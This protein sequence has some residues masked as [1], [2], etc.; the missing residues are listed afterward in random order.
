MSVCSSCKSICGSFKEIC[1]SHNETVDVNTVFIRKHAKDTNLPGSFNWNSNWETTKMMKPIYCRQQQMVYSCKYG[2]TLG[3]LPTIAYDCTT[4]TKLK[5]NSIFCLGT[6]NEPKLSS[7]TL[8]SLFQS[9]EDCHL[10]DPLF[11]VWQNYWLS[12][13]ILYNPL[14]HAYWGLT[15]WGSSMALPLSIHS[16]RMEGGPEPSHV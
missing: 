4:K 8:W 11:V 12:N 1:S 14:T 3:S 5:K 7:A 16:H 15:S 6:L 10:Q 9:S 13:W 2:V